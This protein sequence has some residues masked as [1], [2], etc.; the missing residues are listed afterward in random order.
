M[1]GRGLHFST[2][3][4][5]SYEPDVSR[6]FVDWNRLRVPQQPLGLLTQSSEDQLGPCFENSRD[7]FDSAKVRLVQKLW[8]DPD[9][10]AVCLW[11][12]PRNETTASFG[13]SPGDKAV[14]IRVQQ[15]YR[16][17]GGKDGR[18]P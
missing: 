1:C 3:K 15:I 4:A 12:Q 18:S 5:C 13:L 17:G 14:A 10:E 9:A 11:I 2:T 7:S 6:Y 16:F 8:F